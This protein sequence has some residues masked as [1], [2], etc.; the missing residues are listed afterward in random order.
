MPREKSGRTLAEFYQS[1]IFKN[2]RISEPDLV[3]SLVIQILKEFKG[4]FYDKLKKS[5]ARLLMSSMVKSKILLLT[6]M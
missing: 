6:E 4:I 3:A 5:Y 1:Q 2:V